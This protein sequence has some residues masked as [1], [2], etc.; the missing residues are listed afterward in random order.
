VKRLEPRTRDSQHG[1]Q[2]AVKACADR[3]R[4][5]QFDFQFRPIASFVQDLFSDIKLR[6]LIDLLRL[7]PQSFEVERFRPDPL[8]IV[9]L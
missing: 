3:K 2:Q 5:H 6:K 9:G 1:R 7:A 4:D 8:R